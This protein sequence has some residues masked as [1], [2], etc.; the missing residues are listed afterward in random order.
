M[1]KKRYFQYKY[2]LLNQDGSLSTWERG[3][4]RIADLDILPDINQ[5]TGKGVQ[6]MK[7]VEIIDDWEKFR[8][9]FMINYPSL[10]DDIELTLDGN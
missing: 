4:D 1:T 7:S 2:V 9:N 3:V 8:M 10:G 5:K 6:S